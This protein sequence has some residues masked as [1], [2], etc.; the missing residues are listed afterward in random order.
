MSAE[1]G[2][3]TTGALGTTVSRVQDTL[4]A[5]DVFPAASVWAI[6]NA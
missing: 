3:V 4:A 5:A 1:L 2:V 6:E